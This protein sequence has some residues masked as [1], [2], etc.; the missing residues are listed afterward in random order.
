[1]TRPVVLLSDIHANL[2]ALTA[3]LDETPHDAALWV[4]GDTVGYGP[5][6]SEVIA[7]LRERGAALVAGNHDL[8]VAGSIGVGAFNRDAAEAALLHREWLAPEE[9]DFLAGLPLTLTEDAF[10]LVHGSL[11]E[12]VWEYVVEPR[13]ARACLALA[14][15]AHCC[16]GHTHLPVAFIQRNGVAAA[17]TAKR[18][19]EGEE[20]ALGSARVLLNPGSVGQPRDGDPRASWALLDAERGTV[21]FRRTSYDIGETQRRMERRELPLFLSERLAY[22]L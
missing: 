17:P 14:P 4:M 2:V 16:N 18:F 20:L 10:T 6:P 19:A 11:R 5:D 8:A 21:V 15:T 13:A 22:G 12:P 7:L 9:R 3:V 1:M